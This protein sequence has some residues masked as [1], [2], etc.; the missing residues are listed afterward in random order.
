VDTTVHLLK[1]LGEDALD[2]MA[3]W[4]KKYSKHTPVCRLAYMWFN[5]ILY[6]IQLI[7]LRVCPFGR[8]MG[9]TTGGWVSENNFDFA[10]VALFIYQNCL[11]QEL[12]SVSM[13]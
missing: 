5:S 13:T 10:G 9:N 8:K 11:E 12:L 3:N 7:W 6:S 1:G 4:T 2:L